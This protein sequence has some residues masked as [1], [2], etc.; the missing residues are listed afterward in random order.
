MLK[1]YIEYPVV[2]AKYLKD[3]PD[4]EKVAKTSCDVSIWNLYLEKSKAYD[5]AIEMV[6]FYHLDSSTIWQKYLDQELAKGNWAIVNLY[7]Y[8]SVE[9]PLRER[10]ITK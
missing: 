5:Q 1:K 3:C 8:M 9:T 10:T 6:G 4:L 7:G 2:D